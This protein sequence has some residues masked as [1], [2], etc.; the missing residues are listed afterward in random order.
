MRSTNVWNRAALPLVLLACLGLGIWNLEGTRPWWD[1]GWT[2]SVARTLVERG[3]YARLLHGNLAPY[4]LEAAIPYT[5]LVALSMRLFGVGLWQGRLPGVVLGVAALG[6][7]FLVA[8]QAY[9][10]AVAW[11]SL[12]SALLLVDHPL[13][14]PLIQARQ[15]L[16]EI[17]MLALLLAGMVAFDRGVRGRWWGLVLAVA[18]WGLGTLIKSQALPFL[19]VGLAAVVLVA[20]LMRQWRMA[21]LACACL[22]AVPVVRGWF[23]DLSFWAAQPPFTAEVLVGM[24]RMLAIVPALPNRLFALDVW[25]RSGLLASAGLGL[26]LWRV[27]RLVR[28][29]FRPEILLQSLLVGLCASWIAWYLLLSVGMPRYLFPGLF[30]AAIGSGVLLQQCWNGMSLV[31]LRRLMQERAWRGVLPP[32][33]VVAVTIA[34]VPVTLIML[35]GYVVQPNDTTAQQVVAYIEANSTPADGIET[36]ESELHFFLNRP[37]HWPPDS[38]HVAMNRRTLLA[39]ASELSYDPFAADHPIADRVRWLVVGPFARDG[40][41]YERTIASGQVRLVTTIGEYAIYQRVR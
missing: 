2:L 19:L 20:A 31:S 13:Q 7:L 3:A 41:L 34:V 1:E 4:G 38:V 28:G 22:V 16:A 39:E 23:L 36:Y 5:E 29:E 14:H 17:P 32:L 25:Q 11:W 9:G 24:D 37:Y 27:L 26:M 10:R 30:L 35:V 40:Q 6:L 15:V 12:A 8:Q 33:L 18:C 21:L